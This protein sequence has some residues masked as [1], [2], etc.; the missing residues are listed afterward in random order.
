MK[1]LYHCVKSV[2][3]GIFCGLNKEQFGSKKTPYLDTF[4]AVYEKRTSDKQKRIIS[5]KFYLNDYD[6][7]KDTISF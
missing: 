1:Q 7:I 3:I 5:E 4:H 6:D 2:Q